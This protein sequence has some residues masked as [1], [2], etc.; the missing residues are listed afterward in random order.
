[1]EKMNFLY[2]R[3][4]SDMA[5]D[6]G[7][8]P[9]VGTIAAGDTSSVGS[10]LVPASSFRYMNPTTDTAITLYFDNVRN[11]GQFRPQHDQVT[12][13][14]TQGK[15]QEAMADIMASINSNPTDGF[16]VIADDCITTDSATTALN[17]LTRSSKYCSSHISAVTDITVHNATNGYGPHEYYE[18]VDIPARNHADNDVINGLSVYIPAQAML[19]YA[20]ISLVEVASNNIGA[21]SLFANTAAVAYDGAASGSSGV[22]LVGADTASDKSLPDNDLDISSDATVGTAVTSGTLIAPHIPVTRTNASYFH[23]VA[24]SDMATT[25][26]TGT[27]KVGVYLKWVGPA[28]VAI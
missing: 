7:L 20:S 23:I 14:V 21:V 18:V 13:T 22:E 9:G 1:M 17:D 10:L 27:P 6:G 15:T 5:N 4:V 8:I 26:V 3:Q 25:D 2:F 24:K 12:L 11:D 19:T 28:A 16:T